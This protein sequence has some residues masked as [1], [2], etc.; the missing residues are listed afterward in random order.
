[1]RVRRPGAQA[2]RLLL[3]RAAALHRSVL[4]RARR[5]LR[6]LWPRGPRRSAAAPAARLRGRWRWGR[7]PQRL[8]LPLA[9][10]Q[11]R[12]RPVKLRA[13]RAE[14]GLGAPPLRRVRP[15]LFKLLPPRAPLRR[16]PPRQPPRDP[17]GPAP[18]PASNDRW[19]RWNGRWSRWN[20][21]RGRAPPRGARTVGP[22]GNWPGQR[23]GASEPWQ[24]GARA[25]C[26]SR[27]SFCARAASTPRAWP[28]SS[29]ARTSSRSRAACAPEAGQSAPEAVQSQPEASPSARRPR[30]RGGHGVGARPRAWRLRAC[31]RARFQ[32]GTCHH[33]A[34]RAAPAHP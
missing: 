11:L 1:M 19:S 2:H 7:H 29:S 5:L 34:A 33:E 13:R 21:G 17:P 9:R 10:R 4:V 14:L 22:P 20:G 15:Q 18:P 25:C 30:P 27:A 3:R 32:C 23:A 16:Q 31:L 6:N 26:A 12:A 8:E 24:A 28:A